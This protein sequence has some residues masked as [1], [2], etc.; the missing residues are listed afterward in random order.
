MNMRVAEVARI[1]GGTVHG[2]GDVLVHGIGLDSQELAPGALFAALPGT[3]NHGARFAADTPAAA[4]LSDAQGFELLAQAGEQRPVIVVE[5]IRA[6]LGQVSS[7]LYNNPSQHLCVIGITGTSGKTT[8]S[9]LLEAGL[10]HAGLHVGLIGTTGTR[11]NGTKVPT[12]LTT[13]EA[14][15]LQELF[16]RMVEQ[17]VTHVVMEVSSH[18]LALGRVGGTKFDAAGFSNLTQDHLDFHPTMED[19]F[20]TKAKLFDPSSELSPEKSV[21]CIDD[22]WGQAMFARAKHPWALASKSSQEGD[23]VANYFVEDAQTNDAGTQHFTLNARGRRIAVDLNMPGAFNIT[24][25]SLAI[26]L[27][28]AVGVDADVVAEGLATVGVPG[29]MQRIDAGQDFIAVV[30][31]AHKPAAVAAVLDTIRAQT[32]G[33][34]AVVLGAGGNRDASKRALMGEAAASRADL[35]IVSDDNPRDE[36]PSQIRAA[37]MEGAEAVDDGAQIVEEGD[38]FAAIRKAVQWATP[39]DAIVVAGKGHEVG[40]LIRGV[41]HHFDDREA[42]ELAITE[43]LQSQ[44]NTEDPSN[45]AGDNA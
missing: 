19:Y 37:I 9:Y 18:A 26:A 13:P 43:M 8:T 31:Y 30:D 20:E 28:D 40:Q 15:K 12:Q 5:D 23:V 29:R 39:G 7:A 25:A 3:R 1:A 14:P 44:P 33:R 22:E 45:Q 21:I 17:G 4:I 27:A 2:D 11:I 35:L 6:I 10:M 34:V 42:L 36:D 38:R 16:A 41:Q 32:P 24:N